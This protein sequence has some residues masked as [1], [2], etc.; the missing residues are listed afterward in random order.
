MEALQIDKTTLCTIK[1]RDF[2]GTG[3]DSSVQENPT[4]F[5]WHNIFVNSMNY[6]ASMVRKSLNLLETIVGEV[7]RGYVSSA[8]GDMSTSDSNSPKRGISPRDVTYLGLARARYNFKAGYFCDFQ[9]LPHY[10]IGY[11]RKAFQALVSVIEN[12]E[13]DSREAVLFFAE[14]TNFKICSYSLSLAKSL[15]TSGNLS[16]RKAEEADQANED[17]FKQF[18]FMVRSLKDLNVS[19]G[20][21]E[22][23]CKQSLILLG[24]VENL[25]FAK[26][27]KV[28]V[29]E[30]YIM[31]A[32]YAIKARNTSSKGICDVLQG[33]PSREGPDNFVTR[34][35]FTHGKHCNGNGSDA[36]RSEDGIFRGLDLPSTAMTHDGLIDE[37]LQKA[38]TYLS[39]THPRR[40]AFVLTMQ[41][42]Q[43]MQQGNFAAAMT[44]LEP[45]IREIQSDKWGVHLVLLFLRKKMAC[46]MYLGRLEDYIDSALRL[47]SL[48]VAQQPQETALNTAVLSRYE[49][50]ELH[51]DLL[52]VL[53][54]FGRGPPSQESLDIPFSPPSN[55]PTNYT[56]VPHRPEFGMSCTED[57]AYVLPAN[58]V[59]T[60][61]TL[62]S[63]I[64]P[65]LIDVRVE[66]GRRT[67]YEIGDTVHAKLCITSLFLSRIS[68][69]EVVV[70]WS[71][72]SLEHRFTHRTEDGVEE[73]DKQ[74]VVKKEKKMKEK[75]KKKM[76]MKEK[77][78]KKRR[79]RRRK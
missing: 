41:C 62:S 34:L 18:D 78:K 26:N 13:G 3:E 6:Y 46:A 72:G 79:R 61:S 65:R 51:R 33:S 49:I 43:C 42:E 69:A 16:A 71:F 63:S 56:S 27:M 14:L 9:G 47:Y 75:K 52:S 48:T 57:L 68:F 4:Q 19:R 24:L 17:A 25:D 36:H 21:N 53:S 12:V 22:W 55:K 67:T 60:A 45:M 7:M 32:K 35:G 77:K 31:A 58:Y 37:L 66:L 74:R 73:V 54:D 50:E 59:Y 20:H 38:Y 40:K 23:M 2:N 70:K 5:L 64:H 15:S 1:L 76:K 10:S 28:N 11:Y 8:S 44:K 29:G 39:A 30:Y